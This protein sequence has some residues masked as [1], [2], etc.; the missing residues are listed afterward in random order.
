MS[1]SIPAV[2]L[3][4]G[5]D[6]YAA[7]RQAV[8]DWLDDNY[9]FGDAAT[10]VGDDDL[11]FLENGI[12]DSLGFVNLVLHLERSYGIRIDR[13]ALSRANFDSLRKIAN[14]VARHREFRG[15]P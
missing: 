12:L 15:L 13:K 1:E 14:Y 7:L 8:I 6:A 5:G 11:S 10:L 9:H 4:V 3:P 2:P